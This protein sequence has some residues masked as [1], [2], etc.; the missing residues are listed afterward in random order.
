MFSEGH[1]G[2]GRA[3]W[4]A[5]GLISPRFPNQRWSIAPFA[6]SSGTAFFLLPLLPAHGFEGRDVPCS[7]S[8][9]PKNLAQIP[10][11]SWCRTG[12]GQI[13][14]KWGEDKKGDFQTS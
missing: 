9:H 3:G 2:G 6:Q 8:E 7:L 1:L 12:V 14:G 4:Q 11:G 13:V 5:Y 10:A